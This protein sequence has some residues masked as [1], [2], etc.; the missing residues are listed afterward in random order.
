[1]LS[2]VRINFG[3]CTMAR[4]KYHE[5]LKINF[6]KGPLESKDKST[7]ARAGAIWDIVLN[8]LREDLRPSLFDLRM[9]IFFAL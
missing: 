4:A 6:A 3:K 8:I 7:M 1:M 5:N 2:R 9:R